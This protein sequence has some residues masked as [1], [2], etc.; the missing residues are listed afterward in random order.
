LVLGA[1]GEA[2]LLLQDGTILVDS[3]IATNGLANSAILFS[4]GQIH[5]TSGAVK[6]GAPLTVGDGMRAATLHLR[7]G[8]TLT[9]ADGLILNNNA[10][11]S[12]SGTLTGS[13][14]V[15]AGGALAPGASLG[16][17]NING[18]LSLSPNSLLRFEAGPAG[19]ND[20]VHVTGNLAIGGILT[21]ADLGGFTSGIYTL[22]TYTG[23]L[24][25]NSLIQIA[26]V[27]DNQVGLIDYGDGSNDSV[28]LLTAEDPYGVFA[29]YYFGTTNDIGAA[30]ADA[31]GDGMSNE[32]E[33]IAG[34]NPLDPQ[35][36]LRVTSIR[37][38][39]NDVVITWQTSGGD[40]MFS[41]GGKTNVIEWTDNLRAG[42]TNTLATIYLPDVGDTVTNVTD[43]GAAVAKCRFY[44]VRVAQ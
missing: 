10:T 20:I 19:V 4:E 41:S 1:P 31:D 7:G 11:L 37:M 5:T 25:T 15:E 35:S 39:G 34:T 14:R 24:S 2:T 13:V 6:N 33:S 30:T 44:R 29:I 28:R 22:F 36:V 8:G 12:G 27:P 17:L 18:D 21:L 16:V 9:L 3:L 43:T 23:S 40:A 38:A 32:K 26:S 42:F